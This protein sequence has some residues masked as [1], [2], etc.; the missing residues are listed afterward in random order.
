MIKQIEYAAATGADVMRVVGSSLMFRFEPHAPQIKRLTKMF[1]KA[2][3]IAEKNGVKLAVE[4]HLDFTSD[5]M[6]TL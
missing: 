5:E 1:S 6:L 4:N 3:K 2:V